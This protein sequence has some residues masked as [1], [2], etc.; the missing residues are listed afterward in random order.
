MQGYISSQWK[1]W[2][3]G[4][5]QSVQSALVKVCQRSPITASTSHTGV[6]VT[7]EPGRSVFLTTSGGQ[8]ER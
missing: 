4:R 1:H 7:V 6:F 3:P 5:F 2:K 8:A